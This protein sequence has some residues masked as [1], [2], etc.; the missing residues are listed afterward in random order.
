MAGNEQDKAK[1]AKRIFLGAGVLVLGGSM[2]L[3][4]VPQ[5]PAAGGVSTDTV[6]K[7]GD[8]SV[9]VQDI[10]QQVQLRE[11]NSQVPKYMEAILAKEA[12]QGV[13]FQKE[14]DYESKRT[15]IAVSDQELEERIRPE[16]LEAKI[17]PS[18]PEIKAEYEKNK[19]K[20]QVPER[21]SVRYALLDVNQ[22]RQ[23]IQIPEDVIKKQYQGNM[24][25]YQVPNR[26]H[27]LQIM[28]KTYGKTDAEVDEVR[29]RAEDVLRQA[30]KGA[31]FEELAKKYSE[32]STKDKGGDLGWVGQNQMAP[33]LEKAAFGLGVGQVSELIR[34]P[35]GFHI[36]KVLEKETAHTKPF[37]EVKDSL[38][39]Q[40]LLNEAEK[41]TNDIVDQMSRAIR[42]SNK[43]SLDDLAK[44]YHLILS[45]PRPVSASDPLLEL[46]NSQDVKEQIFRLRSGELSLP[47]KN[48]RGYAVLA[49]KEVQSAHQGTL[50]EVRDR[51]ITDLKKEHALQQA[52]SKA[53]ELVRG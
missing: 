9:T 4:L 2:L 30:K 39:T 49:L 38:R 11:R 8:E 28:V 29:K 41:Q 45:Q 34:T 32:D 47:I 21:R 3:Y 5:G 26:V 44:Q 42:Q 36:I 48:D 51:V 23:T 7:V 15:G 14:V 12:F 27:L 52:K 18:E 25:Q 10:R 43:I 17:T 31:K 40:A 53:E 35:Y 16:D 13:D 20:Y 50:E 33:E 22:L 37:D 19:A 1:M 46:A 6:A 24:Q